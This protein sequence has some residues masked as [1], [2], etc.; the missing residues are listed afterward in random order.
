MGAAAVGIFSGLSIN[1]ALAPWQM[2]KTLPVIAPTDEEKALLAGP[3]DQAGLKNFEYWIIED[4]VA[5]AAIAG[6]R[7]G[8]GVFKPAVFISRAL[9]TNLSKTEVAAVIAHEAAH[10]MANHLRKRILL[11]GALIASLTFAALF[12]TLASFTF[13]PGASAHEG[14]GM[15][16]GVAA[17]GLAFFVIQRQNRV[18]EFEADW[19]AIR[20]L[21]ADFESW[22]SALRKMDQL[23]GFKPLP[24]LLSSHP[25]TE[26]RIQNVAKMI[27]FFSIMKKTE[28]PQTDSSNSSDRAA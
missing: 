6:Y 23:N 22:A 17:F 25:Q 9:M 5:T 12:C 14:I 3:M 4:R 11:S 18:H 2:K 1:F 19:L 26:T 10:V 15:I 8:F 28:T 24:G 20:N 13:I 27:E 21:G 7:G 16:F